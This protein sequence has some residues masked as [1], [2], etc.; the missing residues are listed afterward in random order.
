M[1]ARADLVRSAAHA[2]GDLAMGVTGDN[3]FEEPTR[4][5]RQCGEDAEKLYVSLPSGH[6]GVLLVAFTCDLGVE[7]G[8]FRTPASLTSDE[9]PYDDGEPSARIPDAGSNCDELCD[10]VLGEIFGIRPVDAE[11]QCCLEGMATKFLLFAAPPVISSQGR[12]KLRGPQAV[13]IPPC[14]SI[15]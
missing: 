4:S 5:W 8:S 14:G 10:C 7:P 9:R 2:R 3:E 6:W 13:A 12:W 1:N 11:S 15:T